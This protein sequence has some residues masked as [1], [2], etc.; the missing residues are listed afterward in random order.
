MYRIL[1]EDNA[2]VRDANDIVLSQSTLI[3]LSEVDEN[4]DWGPSKRIHE[5]LAVLHFAFYEDSGSEDEDG[6]SEGVL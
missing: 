4:D 6:D 3:L 5:K 1:E 2:G